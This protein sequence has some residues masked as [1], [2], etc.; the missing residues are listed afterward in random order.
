MKNRYVALFRT[1]GKAVA[2]ET[3]SHVSATQRELWAMAAVKA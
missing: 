3:F 1:S 2:D